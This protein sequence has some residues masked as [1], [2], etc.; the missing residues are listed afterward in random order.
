[1]ISVTHG[2][3][4]RLN[5]GTS[6]PRFGLGVYQSKTG[7]E[8]YNACMCAF[9]NGY[10]HVDTAEFYRNEKDVGLAVRDFL[11]ESGLNRE[12]M[13][14]TTKLWPNERTEKQVLAAFDDS[15]NRLNID[16]I[17]LYLIHS[18]LDTSLRLQQW[19]ALETLRDSGK[20]KSIGVSN[21][22]THHIEELL[23]VARIPPAVNQIELSPFCTR[24]ELVSLCTSHNIAIEAYSPLTKGRRLISPNVVSM[25]SKYN[26][27]PAQ[28]LIQWCLQH[29]FIAIP[30][31]VNENRIKENFATLSIPAI[32]VE[33]MLTMDSWDE[34]Y[35]TGW[36]PTT[37]P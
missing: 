14:I 7:R 26:I 24:R 30:K 28:L 31:S 34:G 19:R 35:I 36:D 18:P 37:A 6:I 3:L 29:D 8:T 27:T 17:D 5:D 20:V 21:Y 9:R 10:R 4:M 33:D 1:M 16:Y 12:D 25:A 11:A 23:A 32:A 13:Y 2:N 15:F 22:G